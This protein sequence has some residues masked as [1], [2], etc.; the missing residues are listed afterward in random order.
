VSNGASPILRVPVELHQGPNQIAL[1]IPSLYA[2]TIVF[3]EPPQEDASWISLKPVGRDSMGRHHQATISG[4][5]AAFLGVPA[6]EYTVQQYDMTGEAAI[7]RV[8]VPGA[9]E[10]RFQPMP[11]NAMRVSI[12]ETEGAMAKAG[13]QDGDVVVGINGTEFTDLKQFQML[14]MMSMGAKE[15]TMNILRGGARVD[16]KIEPMMFMNEG[17]NGGDMEP[18]SR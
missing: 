15:M 12:Y 9:N 8:T 6:G 13:F 3:D 7:M 14:F 17:N 4:N 18:T 1:T 16:V 10:V 11:V 2:I 5:K